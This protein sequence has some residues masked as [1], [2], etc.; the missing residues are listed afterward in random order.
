MVYLRTDGKCDS[1]WSGP[2]RIT[3]I[4]SAVS[5]ELDDDGVT[6]H[7]SHIKKV[8]RSSDH[9]G[10]EI[11]SDSSDTDDTDDSVDI[12]T[13]TNAQEYVYHPDLPSAATSDD[14]DNHSSPIRPVKTRHPPRYLC[15]YVT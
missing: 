8:P 12:D 10:S 7:I 11:Q 5:V 9:A 1:E 3:C 13:H 2:H 14:E 6:R 15:D 4:K